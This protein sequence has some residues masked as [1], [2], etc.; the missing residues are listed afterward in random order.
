[1]TL[2]FSQQYKKVPEILQ[3]FNF[4]PELTQKVQYTL[5]S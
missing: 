2:E 4:A 1:M 3:E 5:F